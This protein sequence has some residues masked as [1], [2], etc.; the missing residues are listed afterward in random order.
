MRRRRPLTLASIAAVAALWLLAA[1][2][3]NGG[4]AGVASVASSTTTATP[5]VSGPLA[6]THCMRAHGV[7]SFPEPDS[8][9]GIPK[10]QV[11][12]AREA[13]PSRFDAADNACSHLVPN[14]LGPPPPQIT[15]ADQADYLKAAACMRHHGFPNFPDPT[16]P[17]NGV[18]FNVPS[19]IN[20]NSPLAVRAV[21]TCRKLIPAGLPYSGTDGS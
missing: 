5:T 8:S 15:A 6:Y 20:Q 11:I 4:S 10:S 17:N 9:G 16:F 21:T 19:T 18:R 2:C 13:N 12:S 1:G 14:G 7:P 3:G